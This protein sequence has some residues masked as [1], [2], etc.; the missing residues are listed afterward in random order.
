LISIKRLMQ[1]GPAEELVEQPVGKPVPVPVV[2]KQP[3]DK[4]PAGKSVN[5]L[6]AKPFA[7][8]TPDDPLAV[9]L[10]CYRSSLRAVGKSAAEASV[11]LGSELELQLAKLVSQLPDHPNPTELR[12]FES[13]VEKALDQSAVL[14]AKSLRE[15][16]DG[17]KELLV[18][19]AS[20]AES[21]GERDQRYAIQ[22]SE[23]TA[24]LQRIADLDDLTQVRSS[25]VRK[26]TEL[27]SCVDTMTQ[28]SQHLITDLQSQVVGYE[29]KLKTV[30]ELV[31]KDA[32]TGIAN[33][34]AAEKRM[35]WHI[36][37]KQTYCIAVLDLNNF[38]QINDQY[39]HAAGDD[40]LKQFAS[41]LQNGMRP[42]DLVA[43]WGGDEFIV[44]LN[45]D[46]AEA[47]RQIDRIRKWVLGDY[48]IQNS[49]D[50]QS[51]KIKVGASIGAAQWQP[52]DSAEHVIAEA[53]AQMYTDK[54]QSHKR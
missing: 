10:D 12:Q 25:L 22:F 26:A 44:I 33:R 36:V 41:E 20:T 51:L 43:R 27:K 18:M 48:T 13:E 52:G 50:G 39:G 14:M 45:G 49:N 29:T 31:L 34:R 16:A 54:E 17:V 21:V 6:V 53:D 47:D 9:T 40:L 7:M 46:L 11:V 5:H 38:K 32:L 23:F 8:P 37:Q 4:K 15:K 19:L 42:T 2:D 1:I 3:A 24:D 30:E 35:E 28:E